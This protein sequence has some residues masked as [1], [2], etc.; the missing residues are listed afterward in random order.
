[1][2]EDRSITKEQIKKN[3]IDRDINDISR[4]NSPLIKTD[5]CIEIDTS[6][7]TIEEQVNK[8]YKIIKR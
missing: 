1:M 3:L 2:N 4:L 7:L 6:E 5:D 8:I